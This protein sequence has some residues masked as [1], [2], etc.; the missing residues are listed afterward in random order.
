MN[1]VTPMMGS[2]NNHMVY[3]AGDASCSKAPIILYRSVF[4]YFSHYEIFNHLIAEISKKMFGF[5]SIKA[6]HPMSPISFS[7]FVISEKQ[8]H[9]TGNPAHKDGR[10]PDLNDLMFAELFAFHV[11][12]PGSILP[13]FS[14]SFQYLRGE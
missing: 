2:Q 7:W 13:D 9:R 6:L 5:L 4:I 1:P 8:T 12:F 14:T 3:R 11:E 10:I